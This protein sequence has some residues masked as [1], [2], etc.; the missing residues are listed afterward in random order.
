MKE[1]VLYIVCLWCLA[2]LMSGCEDSIHLSERPD[3][4]KP[5]ADKVQ[6]EIF[7]RANSYHYPTVRTMD[8]EDRVGKTPWILVFNGENA[9]ATF[10]EAV[11]AFEMVGK[12]YVIL[13]KQSGNSK[14]QLLI[15]ANPL[16][17][18]FYYGNN[19]TEYLFT[20]VSQV[21]IHKRDLT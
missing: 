7:A 2:F 19:V 5:Q 18:K 11:Q 4:N 17:D 1:F 21:K 20:K 9:N 12:R 6:I 16:N 10:V 8:D 3:N 13:T 15:L 14:Y